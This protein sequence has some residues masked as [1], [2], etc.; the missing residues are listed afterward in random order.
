M[1]D[2]RSE[3]KERKEYIDWIE[4]TQHRCKEASMEQI[5]VQSQLELRGII[6]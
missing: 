6:D 3:T 1:N 4:K 2:S 5:T